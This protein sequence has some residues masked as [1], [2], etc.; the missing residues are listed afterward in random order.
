[1]AQRRLKNPQESRG[2]GERVG[3]TLAAIGHSEIFT[4]IH[5]SVSRGI[6]WKGFLPWY[7]PL[8][9]RRYSVPRARANRS[10]ARARAPLSF[11]LAPLQDALASRYLPLSLN[12]PPLYL[13]MPV[14]IYRRSRC[15]FRFNLLQRRL[16][17]RVRLR[18]LMLFLFSFCY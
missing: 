18:R 1:M 12:I 5:A 15:S 10:R 4:G 17:F 2:K 14:E 6:Y 11:R 9:K 7:A 8:E 13:R 3:E 16:F